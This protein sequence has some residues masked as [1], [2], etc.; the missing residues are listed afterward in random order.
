MSA[1]P[2]FR[3][4]VRVVRSELEN[5]LLSRQAREAGICQVTVWRSAN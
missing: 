4:E 2:S 1:R 3:K 5:L